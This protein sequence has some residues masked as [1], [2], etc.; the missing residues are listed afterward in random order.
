MMSNFTHLKWGLVFA[1]KCVAEGTKIQKQNFIRRGAATM[2]AFLVMGV[3][4]SWGQT[5]FSWRSE[6]GNGNWDNSS[7]WWNSSIN[8]A[9]TASFGILFFDNSNQISMTNNFSSTFNTFALRFNNNT[10]RTIGGTTAIRFFDNS[11]TDPF[12]ENNS[13]GTHVINPPLE[14]DGTSTDPLLININTT[15]GLTFGGT[16]NNQGSAINVVGTRSASGG[17]VTFSNV[18]SGT[19]GLY[20]ENSNILLILSANNTY[21]GQT[22]IQ[23]GTLRLSGSGSI[24]SSDVRL[25][26]GGVLE[27]L[28]SATVK[29]V[30]EY[31]SSNSGTISISSGATLT[32]AGGWG[33][34]TLYQNSI[35]GSG[36]LTKN[37]TGTLA[38]FGTQSYSGST[39][40]AGGKLTTGVSLSSTNFSVSGGTLEFTAND[41]I[42]NS[43]T[44][45]LSNTGTVNFNAN[46]TIQ[47]LIATGGTINVAAGKT[48]IINGKLTASSSV[49]INLNS[50]GKIIYGNNADLEITNA[51]TTTDA[52]WPS[53]DGPTNVI[54]NT[55]GSTVTLHADRTISGT[56]TLNSGKISTGSNTLY[57]S[58]SS[59]SAIS[60]GD[61]TSYVVG[62]LKRR[63]AG[64]GSYKF[65]VGTATN[66][67]EAS[68]NFT[69]AG[70]AADLTASF[71]GTQA[72]IPSNLTVSGTTLTGTLNS[73]YWAIDATSTSGSPTYNITLKMSGYTNSQ[74]SPN[75]YAVIKRANGS[76]TNG[77]STSEGTHQTNQTESGGL[78]TV[79]RN[80]LTSFS[81][82]TIGFGGYPLPV[83]FIS[84]SGSIRNRQAKI[85]WNVADE[86]NVSHYEVEESVNGRQFSPLTQVDAAGRNSYQANDGQVWSGANFYRVKAV[87]IDGKVN[88]SKIIRLDNGS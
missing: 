45:T 82:F 88:Y 2:L 33:E 65:P 72:T 85:T 67:Q 10:V 26:S 11:G 22:T 15:G 40:I 59:T 80:G 56:L 55:S 27:I 5:T 38:I 52:L 30:A 32:I 78:V 36:G 63:V 87:D 50:T 23:N 6:A 16:V 86:I 60:G 21:S 19:G 66:Y 44:I 37:G 81:D 35:S 58:N 51:V 54:I 29:S 1:S 25:Q 9:S 48:L 17:N 3:S 47:D 76:G 74:S 69:V 64:I 31:A 75:K 41:I 57:V 73:G 62:N 28:N 34:T 77:W 83:T 18:I 13:T 49:T 68:T 43:S 79:Q 8:N 20:K 42:S 61:A 14:G 53:S 46:E 24:P 7:N 71:I 12:I 70:Y 39:T 84:V 4:V